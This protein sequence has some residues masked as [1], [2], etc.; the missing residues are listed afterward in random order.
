VGE[1]EAARRVA[2]RRGGDAESNVAKVRMSLSAAQLRVQT[3][4]MRLLSGIADTWDGLRWEGRRL[5]HG[6]R[7]CECCGAPDIGPLQRSRGQLRWMPDEV[8]RG[9]PQLAPLPAR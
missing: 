5:R 4:R 2:F 9:L 7:A 3:G 6:K 1:I 8:S